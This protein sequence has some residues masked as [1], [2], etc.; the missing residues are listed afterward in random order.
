VTDQF[1]LLVTGFVLTTVLGGA[2]GYVFQTRA[3]RHQ[4]DIERGEE[5]R[6]QA[7]RVFEE[8]STLM[9]R[10]IYRMRQVAWAARGIAD[11]GG[12]TQDL[13]DALDGYRTVLRDWNDNLNRSLAL[14]QTSFG[15]DIRRS[16]DED[17]FERFAAI[18]RALDDYTRG[19]SAGQGLP[20]D[21]RALGRRL[22]GLAHDVYELNVVMLRR[23][24]D[25]HVGIEAPSAAASAANDYPTLAFGD[26]G[27]AVVQLQEA[28]RAADHS[29]LTP[30]GLFGR[31]TDD[32]V[33]SFQRSVD[34]DDDGI[35]GPR[36]W[37][38][39]GHRSR[40]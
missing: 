11:S 4:H 21:A 13:R 23:L 12:V 17:I 28:L 27:E 40:R 2:L 29:E 15:D 8:L 14:V 33:R 37:K 3:W 1:V 35:V 6:R 9:D 34:L 38:A 24:Q 22:T 10:R 26:Q 7:M 36:T 39:L 30:D 19:V 16:L 31:A 25:G 32:A 20:N 5:Q 18:G